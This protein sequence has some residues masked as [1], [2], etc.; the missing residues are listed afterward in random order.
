VYEKVICQFSWY[1]D[2][3]SKATII[4]S[5]AYKESYEVAKKVLLEGFRLSGLTDALYYHATYITP[6]WDRK[7][8][9]KIGN[10]IFYK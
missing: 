7:Q 9:A 5:N 4:H 3:A 8:I 2:T 6:G 1:C 10:H